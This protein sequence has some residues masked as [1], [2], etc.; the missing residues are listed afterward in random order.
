M[1][2]LAAPAPA[3]RSPR[4]GAVRTLLDDD[5]RRQL[6]GGVGDPRRPRGDDLGGRLGRVVQVAG[7]HR[8]SPGTARSPSR[9]R[10]R[11]SRRLRRGGP[12]TARGARSRQAWTSSPSASRP[13]TSGPRRRPVRS[14]GP[15]SR[16]HRRAWSRPRRRADD[17]PTSGARPW[18]LGGGEDGRPR[19]PGAD[20]GRALLGVDDELVHPAGDQQHA[21]DRQGHAV[22]GGLDAE[23]EAESRRRTSPWRSRH[24]RRRPRRS[25]GRVVGRSPGSTPAA[26]SRTRGRPGRARRRPP[27]GAG[28]RGARRGRRPWWRRRGSWLIALRMAGPAWDRHEMSTSP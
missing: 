23:P 11:G 25:I 7:V 6:V 26:A 19:A 18:R 27:G 20:P 13:R 14:A 2:R 15:A 9:S 17:E 1:R 3:R 16:G 8:R 4:P 24:R 5:A 28:R 10:R 22:A 12:G 21:V